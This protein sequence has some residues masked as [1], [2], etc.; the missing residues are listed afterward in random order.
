MFLSVPWHY[1]ELEGTT[2]CGVWGVGC[3]ANS[4]TRPYTLVRAGFE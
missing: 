3:N 4:Q 2:G 1:G